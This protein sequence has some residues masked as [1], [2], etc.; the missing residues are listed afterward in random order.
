MATAGGVFTLIGRWLM[1]GLW[2]ALFV[3]VVK[4]RTSER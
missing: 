4:V 1:G 3:R 2:L